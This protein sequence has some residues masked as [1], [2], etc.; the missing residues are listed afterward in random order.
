MVLLA[1]FKLMLMFALAASALLATAWMHD[2][3]E[4]I[5]LERKD[6]Q[7]KPMSSSWSVLPPPL[8]SEHSESA[9]MV[10]E[11]IIT[12]KAPAESKDVDFPQAA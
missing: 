11:K 3:I 4:A 12:L 9:H 1:I 8:N 7:Q 5:W 6:S 10:T 2:K